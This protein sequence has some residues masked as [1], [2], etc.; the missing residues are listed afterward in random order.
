MLHLRQD[1]CAKC[2]APRVPV[3]RVPVR[4]RGCMTC[5]VMADRV[6][7]PPQVTETS[8]AAARPT[9]TVLRASGTSGIC[10]SSS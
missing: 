10:I 1:Q 9:S 3:G 7:A 4:V 5:G 8:A 6:L 2:I